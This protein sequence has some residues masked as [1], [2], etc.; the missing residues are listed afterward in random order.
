MADIVNLNQYRKRKEKEAKDAKAA[1]NRAKHGRPK[2]ARRS[3]KAEQA[4][5]ADALEDK[6]LDTK[7]ED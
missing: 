1:G 4:R 5:K 7:D 3:D 6:K 2:S